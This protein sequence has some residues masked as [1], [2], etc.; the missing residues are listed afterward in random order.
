[1]RYNM[2]NTIKVTREVFSKAN[3]KFENQKKN[4][5][6]ITASIQLL[7]FF[8]ESETTGKCANSMRIMTGEYIKAVD[9]LYH[10]IEKTEKFMEDAEREYFD[11]DERIAKGY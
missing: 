11:K 2:E 6:E 9:A 7:S 10:L 8:S 4:L 3:Q 5:I 1:M